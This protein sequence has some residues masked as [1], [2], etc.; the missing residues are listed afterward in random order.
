[1][2]EDGPPAS[3]G[4]VHT[5]HCRV[6]RTSLTFSSPK[7]RCAFK[8]VFCHIRKAFNHRGCW[9]G[10]CKGNALVN[11]RRWTPQGWG[12][13]ERITKERGEREAGRVMQNPDKVLHTLGCKQ[14]DASVVRNPTALPVSPPD[15]T[16]SR[17]EGLRTD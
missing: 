8:N 15:H 2:A 13:K 10:G 5:E 11:S 6:M 1:M 12:C 14:Q 17:R 16:T 3:T 4:C 9:E 7:T